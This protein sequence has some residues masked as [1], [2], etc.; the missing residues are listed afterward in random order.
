MVKSKKKY[1]APDLRVLGQL[2][3]VLGSVA[4]VDAK[5]AAESLALKRALTRDG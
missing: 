1:A 3:D 4:S 5:Q 2:P